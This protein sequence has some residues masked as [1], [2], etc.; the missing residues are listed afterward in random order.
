MIV[1]MKKVSLVVLDRYKESALKKLRSLGLVHVEQ[2]QGNSETLTA[3]KAVYSRLE[4]ASTLLSDIK[5]DKKNPVKI[6]EVHNEEAV[7]KAEEAINLF[8]S[9][10][11]FTEE[12][13]NAL[14]EKERLAL[15]GGVTPEDF[16]YLGQKG[17]FLSMYE[18]PTESYAKIPETVKTLY[19]SS[20][21]SLTR[22]LTLC[23]SKERP[24]DLPPEAFNVAMPDISTSEL[25][26]NIAS[27]RSELADIALDIT[28][29]TAYLPSI[30]KAMKVL[31]KDI[32]FENIYSGM[33]IE[34]TETSHALTWLTG[35][36]PDADAQKVIDL[37]KKEHWACLLSDPAEEDEV[38]TKLKNNKFVSLIY[39]VTDFL[40][41][42]PGYREYD[43][44]GWFLLF[45]CIFFGMIFG[46]AGYGVLLLLTGVVAV[47]VSMIKGK[48]PSPI[49]VLLCFLG[50][51]TLLWGTI[52]CTWFGLDVSILPKFFIDISFTPLSNANP[53]KTAL[54]Q[55]IKIFC[56]SL[57][58]IQLSVAHIKG[59]IHNRK[60]VKSLGELGSLLMLWGIFY[61]VL[62][63]VVDKQRFAMDLNLFGIPISNIVL[64][65]IGGGFFLNFVFI[66]YDGSIIKS[67]LA[68]LTNII[69]VF[70]G[71]VNIF[72]DIVSYIRLWAVALAGSAISQTINTMAG[73]TLGGA[74]IFLGIILL[75][76]GHGLNLVLNVLSVLV[77]GVR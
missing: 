67:I 76:F 74:L 14:K 60:T 5:A 18:I 7:L 43:I 41:T 58:L 29:S 62:Y 27:Y 46:D 2:I 26:A 11:N 75:V 54:T 10:K 63:I 37:S 55:N 42:V 65:V 1:P 12:L 57:A 71:V 39:P 33:E 28:A 49:I 22:F 23:E 25:E 30:I 47:S 35:F 15:W 50:L 3:A 77:H 70:L 64:P 20:T 9:K 68:S 72:S 36:I 48:K 45:F 66:N 69:S 38:P 19:V 17:L 51:S 40:G 4:L 56:F 8:E 24:Q 6:V 16:E 53:D 52:T 13:S 61:I 31:E 21:K 32:E 73:P 59:I 34:G 44:S